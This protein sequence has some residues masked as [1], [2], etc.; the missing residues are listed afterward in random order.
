MKLHI[1]RPVVEDVIDFMLTVKQWDQPNIK[2]RPNNHGK[3]DSLIF[4]NQMIIP[5]DTKEK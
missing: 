5:L 1:D 3:H 4:D 2:F